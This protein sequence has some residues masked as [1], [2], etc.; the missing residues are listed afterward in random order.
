MLND[1]ARMQEALTLIALARFTFDILKGLQTPS[2]GKIGGRRE[3]QD[4]ARRLRARE[5]RKG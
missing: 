2:P 3:S 1:F 5:T 4:R